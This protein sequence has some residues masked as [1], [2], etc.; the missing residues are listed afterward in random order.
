[1][2][3]DQT[4]RRSWKETDEIDPI[5][6]RFKMLQLTVYDGSKNLVEHVKNYQDWMV[7][8]EAKDSLLLKGFPL[9]LIGSARIWYQ[10]LEL[11]SISS[12]KQL[13]EQFLYKF[14]EA[15]ITKKGKSYLKK[16]RQ[17]KN[18]LL[19]EYIT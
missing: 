18:Q 10:K 2:K 1:M 16:I 6:R 8:Y 14:V 12:F 13:F 9:S 5:L 19:G 3:E 15:K 17:G 7:M 4:L 11:G